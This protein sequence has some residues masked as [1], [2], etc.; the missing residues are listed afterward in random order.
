MEKGKY[1]P[2]RLDIGNG[3]VVGTSVKRE[4]HLLDAI[5]ASVE[6]A[7]ELVDLYNEKYECISRKDKCMGGMMCCQDK[8][9]HHEWV[10]QENKL[11]SAHSFTEGSDKDHIPSGYIPGPFKNGK[12]EWIDPKTLKPEIT[13]EQLD[14]IVRDVA[15]MLPANPATTTGRVS[16]NFRTANAIVFAIES[17]LAAKKL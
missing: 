9:S 13:Q 2:L 17:I 15:V 10:K 3:R 4:V 11:N 14:E 6:I 12:H 16:P 7:Q 5:D 1:Y 8:I